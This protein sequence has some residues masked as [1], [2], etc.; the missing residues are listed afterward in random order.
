MNN[1]S[2]GLSLLLPPTNFG[3]VL[4][5]LFS[6]T[7]STVIIFF[8]GSVGLAILLN[9]ALR[10]ENRFLYM[11][12]T[13]LSDIC[14]GVSYY[15]VGVFDVRD[16]SNTPATYYIAPTFLGLSFMA[17]M[18]AQADRYHAVVSPFKY[19]QRMTCNRTILIIVAYWVYAFLV[20]AMH[21]LV[22]QGVIRNFTA[23]GTFVANILMV[24]I[25]IGLNIR[26]FMI[27][28]FQLDKGPPSED[29]DSKRSSVN[30]ILVVVAFFLATWTPMFIHVIFCNFSGFRCYMFKNEGTDPLRVLPRV[31]SALTP[32]LYMR[33]C[34]AIRTTV[35]SRVWRH[36]RSSQG[37]SLLLP[38]TSFANVLMI[39]FSIS[40]PV[41]IIF[42]NVSVGLAILLNKALRNESRFL[43][44]LSTCLSDICTGV[45]YYYV[46]VL[47]VRDT[48]D[49]PTR[50]RYIAPTFLGLSVMAIM[51]AQADRYHAIVSPF[52]YFQRITRNRTIII[53]VAYWVYA[54][55]IVGVHNL[56]TIGLASRVTSVG[57]FVANV[58][59]VV[60]MIG[61]N[62]RL[63][64]IA[65]FQ[66]DREPPSEERDN[67][68]SSVHLIVVVVAF[69]LV[70]WVPLFTHVIICNFIG[71][72]C[73]MFKNEGTD[74]LRILPRINSALTPLLY[75]RGCAAIRKTVI[76]RVWRHCCRRKMIV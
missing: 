60:I 14:T 58:L 34:A 13:C 19:Y 31:N 73:Y 64:I 49:S 46:G 68:R 23:T 53:I 66:L 21:N 39:L 59:T 50:T 71:Y 44:M 33:G 32:L 20:V 41:V 52:K 56:L 5:L 61:L 15:Y 54:F 40:L 16:S 55:F 70:A 57:S 35:I 29:R 47:D 26:L 3:N 4:V 24:V 42:L 37:L 6:V 25:M 76:S 17:V 1:K 2:Q 65:R 10:N 67:K 11:L 75:M 74:P 69:F 43:Y 8:N 30:L 45:S 28:R 36:C 7:L 12:S 62:I 51:A 38:P 63:F 27:A 22:P 18:A 72:T 9:R 48:W